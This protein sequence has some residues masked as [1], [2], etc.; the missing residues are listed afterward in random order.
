MMPENSKNST[1]T[2]AASSPT[3]AVELDTDVLLLIGGLLSPTDLV[4]AN[5]VCRA[6]RS[7]LGRSAA[8]WRTACIGTAADEEDRFDA[9]PP[10]PAGVDAELHTWHTL[11]AAA[12]SITADAQR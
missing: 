5:Q 10:A 2:I 11:G 8:P 7:A 4:A 9:V 6:W 3:S 1:H 12:A